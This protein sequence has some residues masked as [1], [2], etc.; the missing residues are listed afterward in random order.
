MI[1]LLL[2]ILLKAWTA[3]SYLTT[4]DNQAWIA[5]YKTCPMETPPTIL[6][7]EDIP[8][9]FPLGT[10][11][12]NGHARFESDDGEP[13]FH[14]FD[15]DG[16]VS[17]YTIDAVSKTILFRNRFVG[18]SGYLNDKKRGIMNKPGM[19]G[20]KAS[21]GL[22]CNMFRTDFKNVGNTHVLYHGE[23]LYALW[24]GGLP[25]ILD[26][27]TLECC[28]SKAERNGATLNGLLKKTGRF[29]AHYRY[30][31]NHRGH[32]CN[33]SCDLD[34]ANDQT[35]IYLYELDEDMKP[36]RDD[37]VSFKFKGPAIVHDFCVTE[38]WFLFSI[39]PAKVDNDKALKAMLGQE[40]FVSVI[41]F[42]DKATESTVYMIPRYKN[43]GK[44]ICRNMNP[45][46]DDRIKVVKVPFHFS[47]HYANAFEDKNTGDVYFD[48]VCFE[49]SPVKCPI[50]EPFWKMDWN[51]V[52]K[53]RYTRFAIS[54]VFETTIPAQPPITI[55]T[56]GPEFPQ[57]P[58]ALSGLKHRYVYSVGSHCE[59]DLEQ[60][61]PGAILKLDCDDPRN[62]EAYVLEP[63]QFAGEPIFVPKVGADVTK[64]AEEDKGFVIC[65][66]HDGRNLSTDLCIFDVQGKK[67]LER[68]PIM[69]L[70]LPTF[71]PHGLHGTFVED[72][73]F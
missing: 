7:C 41:G 42:D 2:I 14:M 54:P 35:K 67:A 18:T 47:F 52:P 53:R 28:N 9:N 63:Y 59:F 32:I 27:L 17:A 61:P 48:A 40:A 1:I 23:K 19:F 26:P 15:G 10:Y 46:K 37:E 71:I 25:W 57:I 33:F 43:L 55:S 34:L 8:S 38:N 60:G 16:M 45:N 51:I 11:Y 68:G 49:E 30:D 22:F 21:G 13:V 4:H 50:I 24:E 12:R 3:E 70:R 73:T 58:K 64:K 62:N 5:A 72:L 66:V 36:I 56:R 65:H 39:P 20:T 29:A 69:R 44:G 6:P 31:P